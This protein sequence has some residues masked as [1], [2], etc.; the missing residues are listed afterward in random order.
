M[1]VIIKANISKTILQENTM[2]D[3]AKA[4]VQANRVAPEPPI[5]LDLGRKR[6][7]QIKLLKKGTGK[8]M[9]EVQDCIQEL[10]QAGTVTEQVRPVIVLV[11]ERR[12]RLM[13]P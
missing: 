5:V 11:R 2:A 3:T 1:G 7:K 12:R 13:F 10:K 6:R 8:L 9:A 4:N